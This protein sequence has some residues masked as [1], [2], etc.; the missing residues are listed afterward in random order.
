MR[1]VMDA[2]TVDILP[3]MRGLARTPALAGAV[4]LCVALGIGSTAAVWSAI[5]RGLLQP[6]PFKQPDRLVSVYRTTTRASSSPLSASSY[7]DLSAQMQRVQPLAA[8]ANSGGLLQ[9]PS[10]AVLVTARRVTGNLFPVLGLQPTAGRL[11]SEA[12]ERPGAPLTTVLSAE[13]WRS[14]FGA[15]PGVIGRP[16][17]LSGQ[18]YTVV[19]V[20]PEQFAIPIGTQVYTSDLWVPMRFTAAEIEQ[21]RRNF[22]YVIGRL[23]GSASVQSADQEVAQVFD[24][25]VDAHPEMRGERARV[26]GMHADAID[27]VR[28]PL[29]LLF[30]AVCIVL[31][32]AATNVASL[33]LA[34]SVRKQGETAIRSALGA[35]RAQV[36]RPMVIEAAVLIAI[37][38]VCG[39]YLANAGVSTIAA[40]A[41]R[42][43]P[44][45][46]GLSVN[47]RVVAFSAVVACAMALVCAV[48]PAWRVAGT[49]PRRTLQFDR[50]TSAT[51]GSHRALKFFVS[52]Q[53]CLSLALLL[54]ATLA[55]KGYQQLVSQ[56]PGFD[57]DRILS[58]TAIVSPTWHGDAERLSRVLEAALAKIEQIPEVEAAAVISSIPFDDWGSNISVRYESQRAEDQTKLPTVEARVATPDFFRVT[59]QQLMAGRLLLASDD[60]RPETPAVAVVN[61][62]L[63]RR[64]FPDQNPIGRRF[65]TSDGVPVTIVGVVSDVRNF[66]PLEPA[67]PEVYWTVRQRGRAMASFPLMIRVKQ[68]DPAGSASEIEAAIRS[69]EPRA[70][71][72]R[73]RPMRDVIARS[74]DRP[75]FYLA[76]LT[77][78]AGVAFGLT[79][80]GLY[81]MLNYA[82]AERTYEIGVRM[83]LGSTPRRTIMMVLRDG[84]RLIVLGVVGGLVLARVLTQVMKS[85]LYGVD[86]LDVT[87]WTV[88]TAAL[89]AVALVATLIPAVKAARVDPVHALRTH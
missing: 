17:Q 26:V 79:V 10:G 14:R 77:A 56:D 31:L 52:V 24:G 83:A 9:L 2:A 71:V 25:I 21:R 67:R 58:L 37:G 27:S 38:V 45:L 64:D 34:R 33:F 47:V 74:L 22:L 88:C 5:D 28:T 80:C 35:T 42:R 55:L 15:D 41:D 11:F 75:R 40:F 30:G 23:A 7:L 50:S 12:D 20:A 4:I 53:V 43:L 72:A 48:W 60:D 86:P 84:S 89:T 29:Q 63:V 19:G 46:A 70:A 57:P 61:Q 59:R 8:T 81:G 65:F 68:R 1:S 82:A 73:V 3:A 44:Q 78:F 6:L 32:I 51:A 62:S 13:F 54:A 87:V 66:G 85:V 76:L 49:N 16:M 18:I 39:L 69:V 36:A